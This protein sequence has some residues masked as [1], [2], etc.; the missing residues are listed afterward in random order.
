M[1]WPFLPFLLLFTLNSHVAQASPRAM[2]LRRGP[3]SAPKP[4]NAPSRNSTGA[5]NEDLRRRQVTSRAS[6]VCG[7][8]DG[9]PTKPRTADAG[10]GCRE[11][12]AHG[13]W[14]FCPTT[15]L[16][17][18][19][20]G[21]AGNCVDSHSCRF[22][23]GKTG[24]KG[25]TTFTCAEEQFCSTV[26]L[27]GSFEGGFSYIA[28][29]GKNTVETLFKE[30]TLAAVPSV[31]ITPDPSTSPGALPSE[32]TSE[33]A[34]STSSPAP[35]SIPNHASEPSSA[36]TRQSAPPASEATSPA[37]EAIGDKPSGAAPGNTGAIIGGA[38]GGVAM[39]CI[40]VV[41]AI[42]LRRNKNRHEPRKKKRTGRFRPW[43]RSPSSATKPPAYDQSKAVQAGAQV[44]YVT[45]QAKTH[46]GW[47]PSEVYGSEPWRNP[48]AP[49]ELPGPPPAE[50][51]SRGYR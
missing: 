3:V 6:S 49:A 28:C 32:P 44:Q 9:D 19:D 10:F 40:T 1:T 30:P 41:A 17:A 43:G 45:E 24:I 15:V 46:A 23:C 36:P 12:I 37:S 38:I 2:N 11:D 8:Y 25:L 18:T 5:L 20:C 51:P 48:A 7:Y 21:L 27:A 31:T 29:G 16:A 13:L 22:S 34:A 4:T 14:G 47:G 35:S 26:V 50:L 39:V 42:A 33:A